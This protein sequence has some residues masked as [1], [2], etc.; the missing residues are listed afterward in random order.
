MK[1][2]RREEK[3]ITLV[4]L[5]VTIIVLIILAG[6]TLN[7]VLDNDGIINKAK[8]AAEDYEN[9]QREE[10]EILGQVE[11]YI[12]NAGKIAPIPEGYT[13]SQITTEDDIGEGLVIYEIPEGANVN[14]T[15]EE[16]EKGN[17]Q[18]T[19][20]IGETTTNL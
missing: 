17:N 13:K 9:A 2:Q 20:T 11:N 10:Q 19:I 6:V 14:W 15:D 12:E 8:Q 7:I 18:S 5:V 4:A 16:D 1:E 3:G